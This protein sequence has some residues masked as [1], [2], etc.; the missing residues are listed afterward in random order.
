[1]VVVGWLMGGLVRNVDWG[2]VKSGGEMG[3]WG[4]EMEDWG[5]EMGDWRVKWVI[6]G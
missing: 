2:V 1:M 5:G 6:K 4:G 3:D